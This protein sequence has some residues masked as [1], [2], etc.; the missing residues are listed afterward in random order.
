M[1]GSVRGTTRPS[2]LTSSG[3]VGTSVSTQISTNERVPAGAPL[4][5][6]PLLVL[7]ATDVKF[8]ELPDRYRFACA[9][10]GSLPPPRTVDVDHGAQRFQLFALQ[11]A[12]GEGGACVPPA[13]AT[14]TLPETG[15]TVRMPF[16]VEGW[17]VKDV[18]GVER[19]TV[20]LD[21]KP[22]A[23]TR[24]GIGNDWV[25]KFWGGRVHDP[26]LPRVAFSARIDAQGV[27]PGRHWLG[28]VLEGGDGSRETWSGP[29]VEIAP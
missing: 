5:R 16:V 10:A 11:G 19:V 22:V 29:S 4:Q 6:P 15:A 2:L 18:A 23:A 17:A 14:I 7:G 12:A 1:R 20:T 21:G 13:L 9:A 25:M 8:R 26:N 28:L 27:A 3:R 24:Y